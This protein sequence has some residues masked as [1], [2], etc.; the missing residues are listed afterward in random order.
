MLHNIYPS[1]PRSYGVYLLD[2]VLNS[3]KLDPNS[4]FALSLLNIIWLLPLSHTCHKSSAYFT[5]IS[6][7][8]LVNLAVARD[9]G[10]GFHS[11]SQIATPR[12][13]SSFCSNNW[14][15]FI[16]RRACRDSP[17]LVHCHWDHTRYHYPNLQG[18]LLVS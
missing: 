17:L 3:R 7:V 5:L 16:F 4:C 14:P 1:S 8:S 6:A 10:D 18:I 11:M 9:P 12:S 15:G 2:Q 13:P